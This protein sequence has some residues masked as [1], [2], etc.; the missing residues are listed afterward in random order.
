MK[1][2]LVMPQYGAFS[3]RQSLETMALMAE[4]TG[5]ESIWCIDHI[6]IP[7]SHV[8]R[9][10]AT[11]YELFST[12]G[13]FVGITKRVKIGTTIVV[14]PYRHPVTLAKQIASVDDLS[15]GRT[16]F[17]VAFG[18]IKEEYELLDVPFER[19]GARADEMLRVMDH[20]WAEG[21]NEFHGEFYD[22]EDFAFSPRPVQQPHPPIWIG[23]NDQRALERVVRYGDGW[24]PITSARRAGIG[25]MDGS[26]SSCPLRHTGPHWRRKR[27]VTRP[28]SLVRCIFPS[29]S[30][31]TQ[32]TSSARLLPWWA[33]AM[34]SAVI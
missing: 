29:L 8:D 1:F 32:P 12:M 11:C 26:G 27:A 23:G 22:F 19:R 9:F 18:W 21:S 4:D 34:Q 20:L 17:G 28:A 7:N 31:L 6:V 5:F 13:F 24:H 25:T 14:L 30:T 15:G 33:R 16:I 3:S 2:G 10:S